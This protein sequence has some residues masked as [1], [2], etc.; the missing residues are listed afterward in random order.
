MSLLIATS[1]SFSLILVAACD[2]KIAIAAFT[3]DTIKILAK[4]FNLFC[5]L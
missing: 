1:V 3:M 5:M 4:A 2:R